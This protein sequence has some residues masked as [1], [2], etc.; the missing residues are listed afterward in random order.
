MRAIWQALVDDPT[1]AVNAH[2][3]DIA[4]ELL[5]GMGERT[6]RAREASAFAMGEL[7]SGRPWEV[8]RGSTVRLLLLM[9]WVLGGESFSRAAPGRHRMTVSWVRVRELTCSYLH[10]GGKEDVIG[11]H[12]LVEGE[13]TGR[14][15]QCRSSSLLS[16]RRGTCAIA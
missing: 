10:G 8:R 5:R 12:L 7:L 14:W 11:G 1:A 13:N 3:D 4:K 9:R 2:F 15:L 16:G 6:W